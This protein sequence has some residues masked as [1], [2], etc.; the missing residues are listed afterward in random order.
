MDFFWSLFRPQSRHRHYARVD[1]QGMCL[2]FKH[3]AQP[4]EGKE[5]V[6]ITE[7]RLCWLKRPLP[8]SARVAPQSRAITA[9]QLL[10]I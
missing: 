6:E 2:S 9:R 3:C 5:W 10:S 8:S 4:P 7:P 1:Q